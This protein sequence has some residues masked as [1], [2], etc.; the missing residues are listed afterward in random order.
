MD[1]LDDDLSFLDN[2]NFLDDDEYDGLKK[3]LEKG[4]KYP[5]SIAEIISKKEYNES[6]L[7]WI[8]KVPWFKTEVPEIDI[9]KAARIINESHYGLIDVKQRILEYIAIQKH[10]GENFGG[11]LLLYGPPGVG[12]TSFAISVARALNRKFIK[13]S[14]G[15]ISAGFEIKG[16]DACYSKAQPGVI[17][18]SLIQAESMSPVILLDEIDKMGNSREYGSPESVF[19]ELF[20]NCRNHFVDIFLDLPLDL[21]KVVFIATANDIDKLSKPLLDRMEAVYISGYSKEEKKKI[22]KDY[23]IPKYAKLYKL[24]AKMIRFGF[25]AIDYLLSEY[26]TS[27]GIRDL[28]YCIKC[29]MERYIFLMVFRNEKKV[30]FDIPFISKVLS[31]RIGKMNL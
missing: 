2:F 17:A 9:E 5:S 15:G 7:N 6:Q 16:S 13:I 3:D 23:I 28:E 10:L 18:R 26:C 1:Y 24:D 27:P 12:K 8:E 4:Q 30:T 29:L 14:I 11:I 21:S 19:I 22:L 31:A 25:G 20:D